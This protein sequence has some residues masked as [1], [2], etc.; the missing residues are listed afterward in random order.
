MSTAP[1]RIGDTMVAGVS[2][3][4]TAEPRAPLV[5]N[6]TAARTTTPATG[7]PITN[8]RRAPGATGSAARSI[9]SAERSAFFA[10]MALN[11]NTYRNR[12]IFLALGPAPGSRAGGLGGRA[13]QHRTARGWRLVASRPLGRRGGGCRR[14]R[15]RGQRLAGHDH[16]DLFAVQRLALEQRGGETVERVAMLEQHR[17]GAL[18]RVAEDALHLGI[19]QL[20]RALGDLTPLDHFTAQEDLRL[21]VADR[22]RPDR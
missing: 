12:S 4:G 19:D 21:P 2:R 16:L 10:S 9:R 7:R 8:Q 3:T 5:A 6:R 11:P 17:L 18:V 20:R 22:N 15:D 1:D 14:R 13:A